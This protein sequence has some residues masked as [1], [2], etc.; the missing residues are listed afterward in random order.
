MNI[1]KIWRQ[2]SKLD[3]KQALL[4]FTKKY[5]VDFKISEMDTLEKVQYDS[6]DD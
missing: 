6:L 2:Q 3:E 5:I 1:S 4:Q